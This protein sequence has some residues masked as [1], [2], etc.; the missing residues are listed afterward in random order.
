MTPTANLDEFHLAAFLASGVRSGILRSEDYG[1]ELRG[2]I[3]HFRSQAAR[4]LELLLLFDDV[5]FT[6][7]CIAARKLA[8][9]DSAACVF[10]TAFSVAARLLPLVRADLTIP[11]I[12]AA[13]DRIAHVERE[14]DTYL[15]LAAHLEGD[16]GLQ[17]LDMEGWAS[18]DTIGG[19]I[20]DD[21]RRAPATRDLDGHLPAYF[22]PALGYWYLVSRY[23][24]RRFRGMRD[25]PLGVFR[26]FLQLYQHLD[27]AELMTGLRKAPFYRNDRQITN[28]FC[29]LLSYVFYSAQAITYFLGATEVDESVSALCLSAPRARD[30]VRDVDVAKSVMVVL[31]IPIQQPQDQGLMCPRPRGLPEALAL[32]NDP[33]VR[34][35]RAALWQWMRAV[36][37]GDGDAVPALQADVIKA[38]QALRTMPD[39]RRLNELTAYAAV[40]AGAASALL[41][42]PSLRAAIGNGEL[43]AAIAAK[44]PA[45]KSGW[46]VLLQGC[47][48]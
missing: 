27:H 32:R 16:L 19:W 25:I 22:D 4:T 26:V 39:C 1:E 12:D 15:E 23:L 24:R 17:V 18:P 34:D 3:S 35:F 14:F 11:D 38:N 7:D 33:R 42:I 47:D 36:R 9:A 43:G 29:L 48:A 20:R 5:I 37:A 41:R 13:A 44:A 30:P 2:Q 21:M 46:L 45:Q 28:A 8:P 40:P 10:P 31:R 6:R